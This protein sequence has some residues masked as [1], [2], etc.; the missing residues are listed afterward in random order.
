MK[1]EIV[2]KILESI[3]TI[4]G[5]GRPA[6]ARQLLSLIEEA[7]TLFVLTGLKEIGERKFM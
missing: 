3:L 4:D 7:P 5:Q 6:K 2:I 1:K